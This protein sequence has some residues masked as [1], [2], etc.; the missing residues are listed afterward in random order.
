MSHPNWSVIPFDKLPEW[1]KQE[2][3][4]KQKKEKPEE[5]FVC[6]VCGKVCK[7][8]IGLTAHSRTHNNIVNIL[9]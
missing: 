3:L 7:N 2:I 8:K 4:N 5:G 1:K 9:N 6:T